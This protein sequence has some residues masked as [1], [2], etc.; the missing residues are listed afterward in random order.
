MPNDTHLAT[1][2]QLRLLEELD[3]QITA[4]FDRQEAT[5][6]ERERQAQAVVDE[7]ASRLWEIADKRRAHTE[8]AQIYRAYLAAP[9]P[10]E[11]LPLNLPVA[12]V[13]AATEPEKAKPRARI[14]HQR[15]RILHLLRKQEAAVLESAIAH[16]TGLPA[17]RVRDQLRSDAS[18]GIVAEVIEGHYCITDDGLDLMARFEAY[19]QN[20]GQPLPSLQGPINDD[21]DGA[22]H[23]EHEMEEMLG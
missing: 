7:C 1:E 4:D 9:I 16:H 2:A 10:T 21:G 22:D 11:P 6:K 14:G 3:R 19:K 8:A 15:Y 5:E 23:D 18:D 20:K 17:K 12:P 13:S